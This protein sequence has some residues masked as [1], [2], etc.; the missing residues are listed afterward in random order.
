M[1]SGAVP[2]KYISSHR[3]VSS[4]TAAFPQAEAGKGRTSSKKSS[5]SESPSLTIYIPPKG[6]AYVL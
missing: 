6:E 2:E 3:T 4:K 5:V 1:K